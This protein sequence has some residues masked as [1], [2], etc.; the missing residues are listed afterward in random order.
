MKSKWTIVYGKTEEP[1]LSN[2]RQIENETEETGFRADDKWLCKCKRQAKRL[3]P[4]D[5]VFKKK[6]LFY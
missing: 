4:A 3:I 1:F 5:T 2:I 6:N